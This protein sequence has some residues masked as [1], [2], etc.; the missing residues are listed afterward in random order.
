MTTQMV[1]QK[2]HASTSL[3]QDFAALLTVAGVKMTMT[4]RW[5][6]SA[7]ATEQGEQGRPGDGTQVQPRDL[8]TSL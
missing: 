5:V 6:G 8:Q 7:A 2:G 3:L 4:A 1:K